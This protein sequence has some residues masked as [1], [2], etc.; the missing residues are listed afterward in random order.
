MK[1]GLIM[2]TAEKLTKYYGKVKAIEELS[3]EVKQGEVLGFLG[4]NAAG[5]TTTMKIL[6]GFMPPTSGKAF[7]KGFDIAT[8]SLEARK[9]IG[10]LPEDIP[11]Y[12]FLRVEDYLDFMANIKKV[13]PLE[14]T[15]RIKQVMET[16]GL[17]EVKNKLIGHL[18]KGYRQRVGL[19][20]AII[21]NPEILILDEPTTG[22]DPKQI[23]EVRELIKRLRGKRTII[24]S[25]HILPEVSQV[26][27][28]VIIINKGRLVATDTPEN[29]TA[30]LKGYNEIHLEI[31]GDI[32]SVRQALSVFPQVKEVMLVEQKETEVAR[33]I[34]RTEKEKDLREELATFIVKEGWGLRTLS[35]S[36]MT[37]E[38]IF[39]K[40]TTEEEV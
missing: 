28:R 4:P 40:L 5:K 14:K 15:E 10:Y 36:T 29:L 34:L 17:V 24:L 27:E 20:Q 12:D 21:H 31:R 16:C 37:L 23:I 6:T 22:L 18:S 11:L 33:F 19:A 3:F 26:C 7:I 8:Q 13:P 35:L 38:E 32:D 30:R 25:T 9:I 1:G 2:I 39:L